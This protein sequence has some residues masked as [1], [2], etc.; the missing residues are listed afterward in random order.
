MK[1]VCCCIE[2]NTGHCYSEINVSLFSERKGRLFTIPYQLTMSILIAFLVNI[3]KLY[4][5]DTFSNNFMPLS[6]LPWQLNNKLIVQLQ[7]NGI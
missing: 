3:F 5:K 4:F 7:G 1:G 6:F 2:L